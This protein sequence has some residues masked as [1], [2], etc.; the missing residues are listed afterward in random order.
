MFSAFGVLFL[1]GGQGASLCRHA[2]LEF[3]DVHILGA[4]VYLERSQDSRP[5][6]Q[7]RVVDHSLDLRSG[8]CLPTMIE[9]VQA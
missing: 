2:L 8:C 5:Y 7:R 3:G 9:I 4:P 6:T 1:A